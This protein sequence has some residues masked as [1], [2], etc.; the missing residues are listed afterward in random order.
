MLRV[1]DDEELVEEELEL[2]S[3]FGEEDYG[4]AL[5]DESQSAEDEEEEDEEENTGALARRAQFE[6]GEGLPLAEYN[7]RKNQEL[8]LS[9]H[10]WNS[11]GPLRASTAP[12]R[13]LTELEEFRRSSEFLLLENVVMLCT[14]LIKRSDE[15]YD[16][17]SSEGQRICKRFLN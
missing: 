7:K 12:A 2:Y 15:K 6:R 11:V 1:D 14:K 17:D 13:P 8:D 4:S 10:A 5:G 9:T 16:L 3:W